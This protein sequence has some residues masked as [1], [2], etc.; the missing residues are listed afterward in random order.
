MIQRIDA[1]TYV[2]LPPA[3]RRLARELLA[4][5]QPR[6]AQRRGRGQR[7]GRAEGAAALLV[8][9]LEQP[10]ADSKDVWRASTL[11]IHYSPA[12]FFLPS[13]PC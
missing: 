4:D 6:A 13:A 9:R 7:R 10:V 12:L 2:F 8:P 5:R 11:A 3:V 1:N